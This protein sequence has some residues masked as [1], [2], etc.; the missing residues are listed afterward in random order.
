MAYLSA[1][2]HVVPASTFWGMHLLCL[3][4][5]LDPALTEAAQAS[6]AA[7]ALSQPCSCLRV[8]SGL[9]ACLVGSGSGLSR[10]KSVFSWWFEGRDGAKPEASLLPLAS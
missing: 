2:S 3:I 9:V 6:A 1:C 5:Q 7:A 8:F 10:L 4:N